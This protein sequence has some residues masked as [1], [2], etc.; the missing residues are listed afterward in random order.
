MAEGSICSIAG[1]GKRVMGRG[2][3]ATHYQRW[4]FHGDPVYER[5]KQP[6]VCTVDGC[7]QPS[8]TR[9]YCGGHY[10]RDLR[11]GDPLAGIASPKF[12]G[13]EGRKQ[14]RQMHYQK[15]KEQ[16]LARAKL[17]PIEHTRKAKRKYAGAHPAEKRASTLAYKRK[18]LHA[19]PTWL[20]EEHWAEMNVI[21]A[22]ARRLT[23]ENGVP[24][25]V[26]HIVPIRGGVVSGL[27]VPW[28]LRVITAE[29]NMRR[30]R[31]YRGDD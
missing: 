6:S 16:Y 23:D 7:G 19:T 21:Y 18:M 24:Y 17:Q 2:W 26:D 5:P 8:F 31:I 28:N 9:G 1:C 29:K 3:C 13:P 12:R 20:T 15:H 4:K 27:H 11:Y 30:P 22:E 14:Y 10:R 25:H